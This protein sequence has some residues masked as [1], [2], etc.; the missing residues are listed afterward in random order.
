MSYTRVRGH[1]RR[2]GTYVRSHLRCIPG[3]ST[4]PRASS[5]VGVVLLVAGLVV[6]AVLLGVFTIPSGPGADQPP[7]TTVASALPPPPD[8]TDDAYIVQV[9]SQTDQHQAEQTARRLAARGWYNAGVLRSDRYAELCPGYW[10]V[11][12]GPF[13][14][15]ARGQ[16]DAR[17]AQRRLPGA[18]G[19][20]LPGTAESRS[21]CS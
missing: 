15:T 11:Y 16:S 5:A 9:A 6:G 8:P 17:V 4:A 2:D 18:L 3:F 1:Y 12:V 14:A 19:R 7:A 10:V 21:R 13:A 20:H